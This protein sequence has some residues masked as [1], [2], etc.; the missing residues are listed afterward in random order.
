MYDIKILLISIKYDIASIWVCHT[1]IIKYILDIVPGQLL[2][3]Q[4][5]IPIYYEI[6]SRLDKIFI[7]FPVYA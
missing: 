3:G 6:H 5:L 4:M 2:T 1:F 7:T